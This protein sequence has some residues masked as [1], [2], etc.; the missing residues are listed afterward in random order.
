MTLVVPEPGRWTI[1]TWVYGIATLFVLQAGLLLYF[2]QREQAPPVRPPFRTVIHL[3]SDEWSSEQIQRLP[4]MNDPTLF[5]LPGES[6]FSGDAW[7]R[8]APLEYKPDRWTEPYRWLALDEAGLGG[9]FMRFMST[10]VVAPPL[11]ADQPV[12]PLLRNEV[13]FPSS[14]LP[15]QSRIRFDGELVSR[16]L[17]A[18]LQPR[19]WPHSEILSN[20]I[21]RLA[22]DAD[23]RTLLPSLAGECGLAEAN[24][25]ALKI[26]ATARFR[27]LARSGRDATGVG[28]LA[29]GRMIFE[30]HTLPLTAT[31]P[32]SI[33]P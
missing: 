26:A 7:L 30:W 21:V 23:G 16:P 13:H 6:G 33:Q 3:V 4:E 10:N 12:P 17:L 14:A 25:Q 19:S 8:P 31:N 27:P 1:R 9:G 22:V 11:V 18:P 5:A 15:Q 2:G 28:P 29:W 20:T 24:A 32:G